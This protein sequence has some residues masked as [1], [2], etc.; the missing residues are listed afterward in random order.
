MFWLIL[1]VLGAIVVAVFTPFPV[2]KSL[3]DPEGL[4]TFIITVAK[5]ASHLFW[6]SSRSRKKNLQ[7]KKRAREVFAGLMKKKGQ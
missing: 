3:S 7:K 5:K 4:I 1:L 6:C 2:I